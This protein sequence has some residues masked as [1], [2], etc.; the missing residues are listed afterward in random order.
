MSSSTFLPSVIFLSPIVSARFS[1]FPILL[2]FS[3]FNFHLFL[4]GNLLS[5]PLFR[6]LLSVLTTE[7]ALSPFFSCFFFVSS[8][9]CVPQ[10]LHSSSIC[11]SNSLSLRLSFHLS[12]LLFGILTQSA[13]PV[14]LLCC[15]SLLAPPR[16]FLFLPS[17]LPPYSPRSS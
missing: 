8:S 2:P 13:G 7:T 14:C 1:S 3:S 11:L 9:S 5:S 15:P 4:S 17:P 16:P 6:V 12:V 10:P